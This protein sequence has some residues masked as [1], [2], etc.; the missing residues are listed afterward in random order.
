MLIHHFRLSK[1]TVN[2]GTHLFWL[3]FVIIREEGMK[4]Y[5][6]Q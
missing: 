5:K 4:Q 3:K 6:N 2:L 1:K